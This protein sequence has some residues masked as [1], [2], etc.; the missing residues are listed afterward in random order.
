MEI[1]YRIIKEKLEREFPVLE[2]SSKAK[3]EINEFGQKTY[4]FT[5]RDFYFQQIHIVTRRDGSE[6]DEII[7]YID[8]YLSTS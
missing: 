2:F 8:E 4:H 1:P 5:F 7:K 6:L 3:K